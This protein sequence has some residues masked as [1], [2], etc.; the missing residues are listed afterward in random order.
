MTRR[1]AAD[2]RG[3]TVVE[4]AIVIPVLCTLLAAGFELGYRA[5]FTAVV[6]G[7]LFEASR[8]ATVGN[9][10]GDDINQL[11]TQRVASL[12]TAAEVKETKT[13]SFYNFTRVGK[14]EKITTDK[15][16]DGVYD[17]ADGDCYEDANN[18]GQYDSV[19]NAGLGTAD[20]IVRYT[21]TI[22]Y[23]NVMP[24]NGLLGWGATQV[25][26]ASTVLR[27]QPFTSRAMPTTRCGS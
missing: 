21:V 26:T 8:M 3:A 13:E 10:T 9:K 1:L 11:V 16:N 24:V 25:I 14:P 7:A 18:N 4:F 23:P 12:S 27:N 19:T 2:T 22:E 17:P 20:D 5:Y 6:Q 15:D